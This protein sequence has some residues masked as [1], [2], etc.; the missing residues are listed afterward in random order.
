LAKPAE[1]PGFKTG[2]RRRKSQG[3]TNSIF[4]IQDQYDVVDS[5]AVF[6]DEWAVAPSDV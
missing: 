1:N 3:S 2:Q 5:D 6:H 4:S